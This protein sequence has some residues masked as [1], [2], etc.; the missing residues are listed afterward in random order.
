LDSQVPRRLTIWEGIRP[1]W[2][3][4]C[5]IKPGDCVTPNSNHFPDGT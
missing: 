3:G 2:V 4:I 5:G 1:Y